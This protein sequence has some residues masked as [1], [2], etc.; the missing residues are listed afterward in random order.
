M[1]PA[2]NARQSAA[3]EV[4]GEA[5]SVADNAPNFG[6]EL[7]RSVGVGQVRRRGVGAAIGGA[8]FIHENRLSRFGRRRP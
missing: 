5:H 6:C 4:Y 7:V 8:D 1:P 3:Q 2:L